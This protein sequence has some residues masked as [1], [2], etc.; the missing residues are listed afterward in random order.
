M[1]QIIDFLG[2]L[3]K[4]ENRQKIKFEGFLDKKISEE[5]E[6]MNEKEIEDIKIE[7]IEGETEIPHA[8]SPAAEPT[9]EVKIN[10]DSFHSDLELMKKI[11]QRDL[12][13]Q[14]G[15]SINRTSA[16]TAET[17][18]GCSRIQTEGKDNRTNFKEFW[19]TGKVVEISVGPTVARFALSLSIGTKV[20]KVKNLS[21]D[22]AV[23][24]KS[25]TSKVRIE[26]PIPE[27]TMLE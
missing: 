18:S 8:P 14:L 7:N 23:S 15:I 1:S 22:L 3:L 5:K 16:G 9:Q 25:K 24:L 12:N 11:Y 2:N 20:S 6:K 4:G 27:Q 17:T 10:D 19:N 13:S 26:A 21:N